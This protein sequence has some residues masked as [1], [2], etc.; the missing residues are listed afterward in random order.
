MY[1]MDKKDVLFPFAEIRNVQHDLISAV[2]R[3]VN[4]KSSLI[5][6]A[7]TGL[8]K[9]IASIGPALK[10]A[11]EEDLTVFFLTSRHTQHVIAIDT[12]KAIKEQFGLTIPVVDMIGKK[13]MC[14]QGGVDL[15]SSGEFS[16][17][18]KKVREEGTCE[19]YT[20]CRKK[21]LEPTV[22]AKDALFQLQMRSPLAVEEV[23]STCD[24][25]EMC[26][27]EM[28]L[29]LANKA[30]VIVADYYYIF[31]PSVMDSFFQK[32]ERELDKC[33]VI[34][35]EAHNLPGR[36]RELLSST[37]ST[38]LIKQARKEAEELEDDDV[39][40]YLDELQEQLLECIGLE[41]EKI[42]KKGE[43]VFHKKDEMIEEF[44]N[45]ADR[46]RELKKRSFLGSI[47]H[48]LK[49]YNEKEGFVNIM[50]HVVGGRG[51]RIELNH[52][53]LDPSILTGP[54][55]DEAYASIVMSGTLS[56]VNMFADLLGI[57]GRQIEF[58]SPFP[59][60]NRMSLV[61]P[62]TTTKY[63]ERSPAM[64]K[65]MASIIVDIAH[66][67]PGNTAVFFPSYAVRDSVYPYVSADCEKTVFTEVPGMSKEQKQ[68]LLENF[69]AYKD[70]GAV[71]M[72]VATGSFGE[73]VDL[74]GDLLKCVVV[75]GL[76]LGKPD[77]ETQSVI[78]Y[79]DRKYRKGWDY[80]YVMPAL[81]TV[82]Q[83]AGRCIRSETDKGVIVYLD[84]RY[85]WE[86]YRKVISQP[87]VALDYS[88][89][90]REFF[91]RL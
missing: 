36:I 40:P 33:I 75:V 30:K 42:V 76:P 3:A 46:T 64:F 55:F 59:A 34:V 50:R 11:Q 70:S 86:N 52:N 13:H 35:D 80:G 58:P 66:A 1:N 23:I 14:L 78:N 41:E 26:P 22:K 65:E 68:E 69:K 73:G 87:E 16:E 8:G 56:P 12:L 25:Y 57:K 18:C 37:L 45:A 9:T 71:L 17:Y 77:L 88:V 20:N 4:D 91:G 43:I 51:E 60:E 89:R 29:M 44:E 61:V 79:Y 39:I 38:Y 85:L 7:P 27:Y 6:H 62:K 90:I 72:G 31:N 28:S 19:Y 81:S 21:S 54:V 63:A 82:M 48:F 32:T 5:V 10:K 53:C 15:L 49:I 74:P 2:Q 83:N 24:E 84:K 47:A 67:V